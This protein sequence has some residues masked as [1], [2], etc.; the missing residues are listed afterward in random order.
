[1]AAGF[2]S[3]EGTQVYLDALFAYV[4]TYGCPTALYSDRYGNHTSFL[5]LDTRFESSKV[6]KIFFMELLG[7]NFLLNPLPCTGIDPRQV[8][9]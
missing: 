7:S 5:W 2:V 8:L 6:V 3:V 9:Q 4:S 1:M